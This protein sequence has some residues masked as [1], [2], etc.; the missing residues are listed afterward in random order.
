MNALRETDTSLPVIATAAGQ[1]AKRSVLKR[2]QQQGAVRGSYRCT[3]CK[4]RCDVEVTYTRT[5]VVKHSTG[6]CRTAGC[7]EWRD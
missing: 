4:G 7:I 1:A 2:A 3:V 5:G 6:H